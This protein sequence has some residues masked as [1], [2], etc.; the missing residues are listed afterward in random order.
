MKI[1][2]QN[3]ESYFLLYVDNELSTAEQK[4]LELFIQENPAYAKELNSIKLAVLEA[5]E[6]IFEDKVTLYRLQEME[7]TL[8]GTFK[9]SLY[10]N[11][12]K[13]VKGFFS[14]SRM[15]MIASV[16]AVLFL[17]LGY[18][19]YFN[20]PISTQLENQN[21]NAA[22]NTSIN[23]S[24]STIANNNTVSV[25]N[26]ATENKSE[27]AIASIVNTVANSNNTNVLLVNEPIVAQ[28]GK[29]ETAN[30][31]SSAEPATNNT[32]TNIASDNPISA[33]AANNKSTYVANDAVNLSESSSESNE[34][35]QFT[36]LNM[37]DNDRTLYIANFEIDGDK[38]RGISR[39]INALFKRNKN[40]KQK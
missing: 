9:K 24:Y 14:T 32:N 22:S 1:N 28:T 37:E 12:A 36:P 39:R 18:K 5:E 3:Y 11:E 27:K 26:T 13:I 20:N 19:M 10:R 38:L 23:P 16:A 2:N 6:I 17:L 25:S 7:A 21:N 30:I 15:K 34:A 8:S 40:E 29:T 4:E 31:F 35:E 33:T